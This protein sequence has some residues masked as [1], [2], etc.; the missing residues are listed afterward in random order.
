MQAAIFDLDQTLV[1][2]S[3]VAAL[4]QSRQWTS[5][6]NA[7]DKIVVY[8]HIV[9][10]LNA[11]QE[12]GIPY[13]IVTNSPR[14]YCEAIAERFAWH[15]KA[16]V[17]WHC[18]RE[19]KPH[20]APILKALADMDVPPSALVFGFGDDANDV[21]AYATAAIRP[22]GCFWGAAH[23]QLLQEAVQNHQGISVNTLN[24]AKLAHFPKA[25]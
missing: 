6:M 5:V 16:I 23:P 20:P 10:Y 25:L 22:V 24:A 13:A 7:L 12:L 19:H 9:P 17:A 3:A 1:D 8:D 14:M 4:R 11:L 18:T 21:R 15:P 2:S